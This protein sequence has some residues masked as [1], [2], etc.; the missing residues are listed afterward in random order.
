[1]NYYESKAISNS[2]LSA[3][4]PEQ[5]G[6][7]LKFLKFFDSKKEEKYDKSLES[8][9]M[10]H[11]YCEAPNEFKVLS[12]DKPSDK[13]GLVADKA[14]EYVKIGIPHDEALLKAAIELEWNPKWG[15]DAIKKNTAFIIP[16]IEEVLAT[17][18]L[19]ALTKA[20]K[21]LL[22]NVKSSLHT[23]KR[24]VE[25]LFEEDEFANIEY[26]NE[27]EI[28]FDMG[29]IRCKSK[30]DR[31][32]ID[33]DKQI[34]KIIDLKTTSGSAYKFNEAVEKYH[35]YRQLAFYAEAVNIHFKKY[36]YQ[37]ELYFVVV[38]TTNLYQTVVYRL[39]HQYFIK[40][41]GEYTDLLARIEFHDS[42]GYDYSMEEYK[43]NF[44]LTLH[45]K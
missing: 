39:D 18:D 30:I 23:S 22:E 35:Y 43:N 1:M 31:I 20:Q 16:Y 44:Q 17:T 41:I 19:I 34:I 2:S 28:Y 45:G 27:F 14:I 15:A 29:P 32:I 8:G 6:S 37:I 24:A 40:G 38:E 42:V 3:I 4:N 9:K 5:G 36:D 7:P 33:H 25:L 21:E 12:V 13:L 10:I 11:K 26:L